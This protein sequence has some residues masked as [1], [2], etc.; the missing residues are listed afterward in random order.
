MLLRA[1][2]IQ[3]ALHFCESAGTTLL[4]SEEVNHGFL[5]DFMKL[6]SEFHS[7]QRDFV[8]PKWMDVLREMAEKILL[9]K[10]HGCVIIRAPM[11]VRAVKAKVATEQPDTASTSPGHQSG[12]ATTTSSP[13]QSSDDQSG[14]ATTSSDDQ[15]SDD[16]SGTATT[17]AGPQ[18]DSDTATTSSPDQSGTA[19]TSSPDQSGTA[20]TSSPDQS[21][22]ATTAAG[23]QSGPATTAAGLQ[24]GPATT[25]A[26][27]QSG[28]AISSPDHQSDPD[29]IS[30]DQETKPQKKRN[31]LSCSRRGGNL[32]SVHS[33]AEHNFIQGLIRAHTNDSPFTWI[34]GSDAEQEGIWLWSDGSRFTFSYWEQGEPN[35]V[36]GEHCLYTYASGSTKWNDE[37]CHDALP[38][39]CARR[40]I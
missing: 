25:A 31:K 36:R 32:A 28:P 33:F 29:T 14:T 23:L 18:T 5:E 17:A 40:L 38:S 1:G 9:E 20:T 15:S 26:G 10:Q 6:C 39:V 27:L 22:I 21:G 8:A 7:S 3:Q 24:S 2:Y 35:N 34:G 19:T 4:Y 13:D 12:T 37:S 30:R 16:Q 11:K